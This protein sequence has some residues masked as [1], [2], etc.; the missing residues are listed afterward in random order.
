MNT[1]DIASKWPWS[2][3]LAASRDVGRR[4][5]DGYAMLLD[6]LERWRT[7]RGLPPGRDAARLF[8]K[9]QVAVK[10]REAL[11]LELWAE[12]VRWYLLQVARPAPQFRHQSSGVRH[13]H[14]DLAGT[15]RTRG[16]GDP[17]DLPSCGQR[18]ER[19]RGAEPEG[20]AGGREKCGG[21]MMGRQNDGKAE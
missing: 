7:G 6:W 2:A 18:T 1:Q 17:P 14:P 15:A 16:P 20:P 11:Q 12:A 19:L 4:E 8:W 9:A 10:P 5:R 13:R 21:R 3:D